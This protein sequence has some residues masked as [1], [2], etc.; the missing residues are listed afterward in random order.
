ML[1]HPLVIG[2]GDLEGNGGLPQIIP[3]DCGVS[4]LLG[5]RKR[6]EEEARENGDDGHDH[7]E[8]DKGES[9]KAGVFRATGWHAQLLPAHIEIITEGYGVVNAC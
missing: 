2:Y 1:E 3:T 4:L 9:L 5:L 8:F 7:Q 6:G